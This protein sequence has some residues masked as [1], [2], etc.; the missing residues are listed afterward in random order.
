MKQFRSE[1]NQVPVNID[2]QFLSPKFQNVQS[3]TLSGRLDGCKK[4]QFTVLRHAE[5]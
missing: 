3:A 1:N 2:S 5:N 4:Y